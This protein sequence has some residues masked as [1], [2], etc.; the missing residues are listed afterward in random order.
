MGPQNFVDT[1]KLTSRLRKDQGFLGAGAGLVGLAAGFTGAVVFGAAAGL[2]AGAAVGAG[3][4]LRYMIFI[5][6]PPHV[7]TCLPSASLS[8]ATISSVYTLAPFASTFL[9]ISD[10][11][12]SQDFGPCA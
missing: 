9:A 6:P 4:V 8:L 5:V 2:G 3:E 7:P 11:K 12:S 1:E 10:F